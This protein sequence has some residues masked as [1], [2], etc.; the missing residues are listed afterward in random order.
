MMGLW[1]MMRSPLMVGAELTKND[2]FTLS[3]LTNREL[4]E[5]EKATHCA[6]PIITDSE[7]SIWVA[8]RKDGN[9]IYVGLFNL[10]DERRR[11]SISYE[12]LDYEPKSVTNI[13]NGAT[14]AAPDTLT[15]N[16]EAHDTAIFL[17]K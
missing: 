15:A 8:P 10:S 16:L 4:L 11:L 5:I 17:L 9:G 7:K 2:E 1:C 6:H 14:T 13:W 3:L 12:S